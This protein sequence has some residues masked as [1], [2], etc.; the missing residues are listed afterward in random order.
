MMLAEFE[1]RKAENMIRRGSGSRRKT[2]LDNLQAELGNRWL[3][4]LR[5]SWCA[6]TALFAL[7][8]LIYVPVPAGAKL[9]AFIG[10]FLL[11]GF[12]AGFFR[13]LTALIER[14]RRL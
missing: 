5:L 3:W 13:D 8:V 12:L 10:S 9:A 7:A 6:L 11:G 2:A 1:G 4:R 14:Y